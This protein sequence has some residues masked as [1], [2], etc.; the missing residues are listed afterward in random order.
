MGCLV[1]FRIKVDLRVSSCIWSPLHPASAWTCNFDKCQEMSG[2]VQTTLFQPVA[3]YVLR[4][5]SSSKRHKCIIKL[6]SN[7][8]STWRALA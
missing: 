3:S 8:I 7:N 2:I 6:H 5:E 4:K 1:R